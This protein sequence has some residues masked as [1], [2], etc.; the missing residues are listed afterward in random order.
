[1]IKFFRK[2]R[3]Q[4]LTENK[5]SKYLLYAVGEIVLVVI[6]ILIA[7]SINNWNDQRKSRQQEIKIL[8]KLN[9]DLKANLTEIQ[10]INKTTQLR[11]NSCSTIL[12]Y[13]KNNKPLDD[14]LKYCF[15]IIDKDDLFNNANTTYK[16]IE[17]QGLDVIRND[18]LQSRI[19]WIYERH[20]K[21]I[22]RREASNLE[23]V[24]TDLRPFMKLNF[25]STEAKLVRFD[26]K[27]SLNSPTDLEELR[28]NNQ[29][30]NVIIR[31]QNYM[32]L[33]LSWQKETMDELESLINEV[34]I[35]IKKG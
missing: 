5:F 14:S 27:Y 25:E 34:E 21:N 2:I 16:Y 6:G 3:Q 9:E 17:N 35:E 31:L 20:F 26:I 23:I 4:L 29:F 30:R 24:Q 1:M 13:F 22:S 33:R 32:L 18:E 10:G 7:L 19:T 12:N 15:E 8:R 28:K 11:I